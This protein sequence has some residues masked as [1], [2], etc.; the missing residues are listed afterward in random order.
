[1]TLTDDKIKQIYDRR[2]FTCFWGAVDYMKLAGYDEIE[3]LMIASE[4]F[5]GKIWD[6]VV[7]ASKLSKTNSGGIMLTYN[8]ST[9]N[10]TWVGGI[11]TARM[12][13][14]DLLIEI[15]LMTDIALEA[16]LPI[17]KSY[18]YVRKYA[19]NEVLDKHIKS[20]TINLTTELGINLFNEGFKKI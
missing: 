2:K 7:N 10:T 9:Y 11:D 14:D 4:L 16:C 19:H 20:I 12:E 3:A 13:P 15:Y 5:D 6:K 18:V 1:M 8:D 17:Y